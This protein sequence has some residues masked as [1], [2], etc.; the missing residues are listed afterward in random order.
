MVKIFLFSFLFFTFNTLEAFAINFNEVIFFDDFNGPTLEDDP[1][2]FTK[3]PMCSTRPEWGNTGAC[4][5][6]NKDVLKQVAKLNKCRWKLWDGYAIHG[7]ENTYY[8]YPSQVKVENGLLVITGAPTNNG[9]KPGES[10]CNH[11]EANCPFISGGVDTRPSFGGD[12]AGFDFRYG[13]IEIRARFDL[14]P[15]AFPALWTFISQISPEQRRVLTNNNLQ[16]QEM[17]ILEIFPSSPVIYRDYGKWAQRKVSSVYANA[18]Q[19]F[20]W[21]VDGTNKDY[22]LKSKELKAGDFHVYEVEWNLEYIKYKIDG[23]VT[24]EI[25]L[26]DKK[27]KRKVAIPDAEAYLII[28]QQL[29]KGLEIV[30]F[31]KKKLLNDISSLDHEV[32]MQIDWVKVSSQKTKNDFPVAFPHPPLVPGLDYKIQT[33]LIDNLPYISYAKPCTFGGI[34]EGNSCLVTKL[35][36]TPLPSSVDYI[37][38][39]SYSGSGPGVYYINSGHSTSYCPWGGKIIQKL[40]SQTGTFSAYCQLQAFPFTGPA[41]VPN[42]HYSIL[43]PEVQRGFGIY[44]PQALTTPRCPAGG[45]AMDLHEYY[46]ADRWIPVC[47]VMEFDRTKVDPLR[48]IQIQM[49]PDP[50]KRTIQ[51]V[52]DL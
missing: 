2:C 50:R 20:H 39:T 10:S 8:Y 30:D 35:Q 12:H 42:V 19:T 41:L 52:N 45:R 29:G 40:V 16:Y 51:Y 49:H 48:S 7:K 23:T 34:E 18:S 14:G 9:T 32:Q 36:A 47:Q 28:N 44:Y 24:S 6:L 22:I 4:K 37:F 27:N 15:G 46:G 3:T 13:K 33:R 11:N 31:F 26:G 43:A 17:D 5:N 21:G 38:E 25:K 1:G